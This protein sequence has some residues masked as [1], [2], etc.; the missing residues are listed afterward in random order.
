[1]APIPCQKVVSNGFQVYKRIVIFYKFKQFYC[2]LL[3]GMVH[4]KEVHGVVLKKEMET[5]EFSATVC[6]AEHPQL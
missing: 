2:A 3:M 1:M 6:M 5:A 4:N